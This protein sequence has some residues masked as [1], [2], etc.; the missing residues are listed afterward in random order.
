MTPAVTRA[1]ANLLT[2][3]R[4]A[5][6]AWP[7]RDVMRLL[8]SAASSPATLGPTARGLLADTLARGTVAMLARGGGW[9]RHGGQ[10]LWERAAAPPLHFTANL[11]R[12]LQWVLATP[13][14]GVEQPPLALPGELTLAEQAV[15]VSLLERL[16]PTGC[17]A[18]LLRQ[19]HLRRAPLVLLASAADAARLAPLDEA[20][21]FDVA[22]L[23]PFVEGLRDVLSGAWLAAEAAKQGEPRPEVLAAVGR[24]QAAVLDAFLAAIDGAG[25]RELAGFLVDAMAR[26]LSSPPE[27]DA[28]GG[29]LAAMAPLRERLDARRQSAA[30]LRALARLHA[31]DREHRDT[32]FIDDGYE[33]AQRLVKDWE[34]LGEPGFSAA[35]RLVSQLDAL[36]A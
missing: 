30:A 2:L 11:V 9:V 15:V 13:L 32:R 12:L 29:G 31:W 14:A 8:L 35:A 4:V 27:V 23:A 6:G 21:R 36:P 5:V 18:A 25:R 22:A 7:A 19:P 10:R 24:A 34:R 16:R 28:Y 17:G 33:V 1:E 26:W 20:P 3:A